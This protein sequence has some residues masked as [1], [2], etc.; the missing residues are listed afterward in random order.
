M[1]A[2]GENG[3]LNCRRPAEIGECVERGSNG[4]PGVENIIDQHNR[5]P[6]QIDGEVGGVQFWCRSCVE[7]V[8]M[9]ADVERANGN[10]A[11]L[12]LPHCLSDSDRQ[13]NASSVDAHDHEAIGA[14]I[15]LDDLMSDSLENSGYIVGIQDTR[16]GLP[17]GV[18]GQ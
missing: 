11:V 14:A 3:E 13:G 2:I 6:S 5:H 15:S 1:A 18:G 4:P 16:H 7:V 8:P 17:A 9:E 10:V 12:D